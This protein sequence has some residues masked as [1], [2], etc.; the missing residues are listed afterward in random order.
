MKILIPILLFIIFLYACGGGS[1]KATP[2]VLDSANYEQ[3]KEIPGEISKKIP[4]AENKIGQKAKPLDRQY[5]SQPQTTPVNEDI[6]NTITKGDINYVVNDTMIVGTM[7][8]VNMTISQ[9]VTKEKIISEV[10]SFNRSNLRTDSIRISPVMRARLIDPSDGVNFRI[11]S[12]TNDEQFLE[13]GDYTRWTWNVTP[14][15]K[16]NNSLSLVVDIMF[17]DKSKSIQVY[18]G[19]IY[20]YSD[21]TFF[22]K[23]WIF[24]IKNWQYI[25]SSLL[26]PILIFLYKN[27]KVQ[28][29]LKSFSIKKTKNDN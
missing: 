14:L 20:V 17:N 9:G 10:E 27:N 16:G 8:E 28:T 4:K 22:Q 5:P 18:D 7:T 6:L 3:P 25:F 1:Y 12:K 21:K 29:Y 11:V 13:F 2:I 15:V 19:V 26:I 23:L 24:F